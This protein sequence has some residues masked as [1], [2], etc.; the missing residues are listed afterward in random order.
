MLR[1]H[2]RA[3]YSGLVERPVYDWPDGSRLAV[4]VALNVEHWAFAEGEGS[5]VAPGEPWP[6]VRAWAWREYGN[7]VGIWYLL[8]LFEELGLP[9]AVNLNSAVYDHCPEV[10]VP[11]RKRNDE[12]VGH[13]RT[14]GERQASYDEEGERALIA[15]ATD[16]F[17]RHEG[18]PPRGWL[19]PYFSQTLITPDLLKEAGYVY[20]L[21]WHDDDQPHW[22][23]T[24][25]G[26]L[27]AVPYPPETNDSPAVVYRHAMADAFADQIVDEFDEFLRLSKDRPLVCPI[28]LHPF[29][30]GRPF[31]LRHLR[32]ALEHVVRHRDAIW[33]TR[34]GAIADAAMALP[35]GTVPG[36][37]PFGEGGPDS[38]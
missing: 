30:V 2:D 26:P 20:T 11:F 25:H 38:A 12:I 13:G 6:N 8:E 14:N 23:N 15:E 4:Y 19:G 21:D 10:V 33:L 18:K 37:G 7:R 9:V 28:A 35:P 3:Q 22:L 24:T 36:P 17:T 5:V 34:P 1:Y 31:R 27:L 32:R 16:A 29:V